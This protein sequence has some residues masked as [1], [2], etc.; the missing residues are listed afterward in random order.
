[1]NG[2]KAVNDQLGHAAGDRLL[3][4]VADRFRA[5][6]PPTDS[7]ARFGGDE[8]AILVGRQ[9]SNREAEEFRERIE[10][11]LEEPMELDGALV[12][13]GVAA[14]FALPW[15]GEE[16]GTAVMERADLEMYRRK[17]ELK[18]ACQAAIA[19]NTVNEPSG[20]VTYE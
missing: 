4:R 12:K 7:L 2:F 15:S 16:A 10:A 9:L 1:M 14:G 17:N 11:T 3:K 18:S 19:A 8:F 6:L 13:V 20:R 5:I